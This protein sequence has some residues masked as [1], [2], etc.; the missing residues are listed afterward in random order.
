MAIDLTLILPKQPHIQPKVAMEKRKL[1]LSPWFHKD[2]FAALSFQ[3]L[4]PPPP[5]TTDLAIQFFGF[6]WAVGN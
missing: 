3:D 5:V 2:D 4:P 6:F 1:H